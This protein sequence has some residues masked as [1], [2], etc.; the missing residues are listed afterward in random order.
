MMEKKKGRYSKFI[1]TAV[2]VLNSLFTAA[3]LYVFLRVGSEPSALI[4]AWFTFTTGELLLLSN[5]KKSKIK[6]ENKE[7]LK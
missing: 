3:V 4:A 1:I 5:I 6:K 7:D 2:I